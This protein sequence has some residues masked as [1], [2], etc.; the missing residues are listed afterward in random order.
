MSYW[1]NR[2][3]I[4][5]MC[6]LMW[7]TWSTTSSDYYRLQQGFYSE[8]I[9]LN[10]YKKHLSMELKCLFQYIVNQPTKGLG[11]ELLVLE[12]AMSGS[13]TLWLQG[14]KKLDWDQWSK[15]NKDATHVRV[16]NLTAKVLHR[17][18]LDLLSCFHDHTSNRARQFPSSVQPK[19]CIYLSP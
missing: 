9:N 14:V 18:S 8:P 11:T 17:I 1:L 6:S 13:E 15:S 19:H 2:L 10:S 4:S 12:D 7:E 3:V 5:R 16:D